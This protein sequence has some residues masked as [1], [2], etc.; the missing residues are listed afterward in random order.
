MKPLHST[1]PRPL[2]SSSTHSRHRSKLVG[3]IISPSL[4]A[5]RVCSRTTQ[6]R[7]QH[8]ATASP[9]FVHPASPPQNCWTRSS[10]SSP[11]LPPNWGNSSRSSPR[12][13][14]TKQNATTSSRPGTIGG[15]ST[16]TTRPSRD[17]AGSFRARPPLLQGAGAVEFSS[18][19][20][21]PRNLPAR[22]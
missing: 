1:P 12:F 20:T 3:C 11:C 9:R 5:P 15:P 19:R 2:P 14:K 4:N 7:R 17:P 22:R 21:R 16:R 18:S 13:T 8:S 10:P 6:S